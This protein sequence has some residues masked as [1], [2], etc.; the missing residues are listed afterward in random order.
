MKKKKDTQKINRKILAKF[1][2]NVCQS[3]QNKIAVLIISNIESSDLEVPNA[4]IKEAYSAADSDQKEFLNKHFDLKFLG[5]T[6]KPKTIQDAYKICKVDR[7]KIV[8]Y[9]SPKTKLQKQLNSLVDLKYIALALNRGK[10]L[11]WDNTDQNKYYP[12]FKRVSG[13][14]VFAGSYCDGDYFL[15]EV[16]FY[17]L[18]KENSDYAAKTF[19]KTYLDCLPE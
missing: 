5:V 4:L 11:N 7:E 2:P 18:T 8:P 19:E 13:R 3:W 14:W 12:W 6:K 15:G 16:G 9:K 1:Y 17:F 10:E